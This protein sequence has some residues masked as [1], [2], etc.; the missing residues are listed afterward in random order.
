MTLKVGSPPNASYFS[1]KFG[2]HRYC[3]SADIRFYI[4]LVTTW[5]KGYLTRYGESSDGKLKPCQ[6]WWPQVLQKCKYNFFE[7]VTWPHNQKATWLWRWGPPT[8]SYY[9]AKLGGHRYCGRRD[10]SLYIY[11]V[12]TCSKGYV[13]WWMLSL[14]LR[15]HTL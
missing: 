7:F 10:I 14:T 6:V 3:G 12:T 9:S 4:F 1:A 5:S 13:T 11:H 15:H 2:D 8:A